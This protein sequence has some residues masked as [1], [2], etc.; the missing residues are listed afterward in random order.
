MRAWMEEMY[1]NVKVGA[2]RDV[3]VLD[4]KSVWRGSSEND[5]RTLKNRLSTEL[6]G[7]EGV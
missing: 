5:V 6:N 3:V 1:E 7:V 4:T 2:V